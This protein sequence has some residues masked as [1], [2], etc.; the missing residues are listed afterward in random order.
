MGRRKGGVFLPLDV[1]F[2]DDARIVEAGERAG[3]LY[4]AMSLKCKQL[5]LDGEMTRAQVARLGIPGTAARLKQL[6]AVDAV[7]ETERGWRLVAWLN[8]N[9]PAEVVLAK[10]RADSERKRARIP[11]GIGAE[12]G[13]RGRDRGRTPLPPTAAPPDLTA[14]CKAHARDSRTCPFCKRES[15]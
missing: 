15:A 6:V 5:L 2:M 13:R 10:R 12:S 8:H 11:N 14:L 7:E 1:G 3:W 9:E 4:L